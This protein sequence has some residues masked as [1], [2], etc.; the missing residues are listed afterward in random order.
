[1]VSCSIDREKLRLLNSEFKDRLIKENAGYILAQYRTDEFLLTIY[2]NDKDDTYKMVA[3]GVDSKEILKKYG[4][5][6]PR[7]SEN[8]IAK[9][10]YGFIDTST[11]IG[12]D[13]VG[14]GDFLAP[15]V[16][17]AA[18]SDKATLKLIEEHGIVDS[19]RLSD[20]M[21][22][23][24]VGAILNNVHYECK[25]LDNASY[26]E[27]IARGININAVKAKMH[28]EVL[29]RLHQRCPYVKKVYMDQFAPAKL[30][31]SYLE[32]SSKIERG[33]YFK[34]KGES[35]YPSVALASCIARYML[36]KEIVKLDERYSINIPL[37]ASKIVDEFAQGFIKRYG[38]VEFDKIAKKNFKNYKK[39]NLG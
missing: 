7:K 17:C 4:L 25:I 36:L 10:N 3:S 24:S 35:A 11:Q 5:E 38:K 20:E 33:I 21:I 12:S 13:E 14:T 32:E 34:T 39:L 15:I 22:L 2:R 1:M 30:Y 19:K 6:L 28:N 29:F 27:A 26:N 8:T 16:V 23:S 9:S 18:F 37:G 31:Y